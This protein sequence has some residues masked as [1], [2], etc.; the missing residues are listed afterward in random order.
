MD[1]GAETEEYYWQV[2][3]TTKVIVP[4]RIYINWRFDRI[5][6]LHPCLLEGTGSSLDC[7]RRFRDFLKR[8]SDKGLR[9]FAINTAP[10][11]NTIYDD[12]ED[13]EVDDYFLSFVPEKTRLEE[14]VLFEDCPL[15]DWENGKVGGLEFYQGIL[16]K[17]KARRMV[18]VKD[19]LQ[20]DIK[21]AL[22]KEGNLVQPRPRI[23][24]RNIR[25]L[26]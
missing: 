22:E 4:P 24:A 10:Y 5:C 17:G 12:P 18:F 8:T 16:P 26:S 1:F 7:S 3:L 23:K 19:A 15:M 6:V 11:P 21:E 20:K 25:L 2:K 14:V 9:Y 13:E